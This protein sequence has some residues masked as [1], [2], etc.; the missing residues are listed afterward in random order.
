MHTA[1]TTTA[2]IE[3]LPTLFFI[4]V[5]LI[6]KRVKRRC[7]SKDGA[8][9]FTTGGRAVRTFRRRRLSRVGR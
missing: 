1:D 8:G 9:V 7:S 2:R 6:L 5:L 4:V 3:I